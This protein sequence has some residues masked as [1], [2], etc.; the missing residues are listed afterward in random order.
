MTYIDCIRGHFSD[1]ILA[2]M[3]FGSKARGDTES[4]LDLLILVDVETR[5]FRSKL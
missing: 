1:H 2:V 3:L 5:E 4:D